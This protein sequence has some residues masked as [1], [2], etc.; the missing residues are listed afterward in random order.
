MLMRASS[1]SALDCRTWPSIHA[2]A[3]RDPSVR[4]PGAGLWH[5]RGV[6]PGTL[7]RPLWREVSLGRLAAQVAAQGRSRPWA[8]LT[9]AKRPL[10]R[11]STS[12]F[13][14]KRPLSRSSTSWF[15]AQTASL[16]V[17][18][19]LVWGP[20]GLSRGR[21]RPGL[22]PKRPLSRSSTSCPPPVASSHGRMRGRAF[23]LNSISG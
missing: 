12:W 11:S 17:V 7:I 23:L 21:R 4:A 1:D 10:S 13:E 8:N 9:E 15:E 14:A 3:P 6:D 22:R 5:L 2:S 18:D 20:N 16:E 19:I